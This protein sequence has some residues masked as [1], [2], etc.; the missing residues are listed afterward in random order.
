[1]LNMFL[2]FDVEIWCGGWDGIETKFPE[3]FSRY[4]YGRSGKGDFGLPLILR[5]LSEHELQATFFVEPLFA[6][7]FGLGPLTEI[8]NLIRDAGQDVQLHVHPEW[9]DE[10]RPPILATAS[11]K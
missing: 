8:V 7:R 2:T 11:H 4:V 1:M 5:L 3:A 6:S 9:T 10:A